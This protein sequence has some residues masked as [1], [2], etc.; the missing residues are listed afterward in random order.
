PQLQVDDV[1][2]A[3]RARRGFLELPLGI[4]ELGADLRDLRIF[5]ADLGAELLL[6]LAEARARL[7]LG[8]ARRVELA[9]LL[10]RVGL[11]PLQVEARAGAGL[12]QLA[13]LGDALAREVQARADL[14]RAV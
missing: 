5:A 12:H 9:L 7:R 13:I 11:D 1:A 14:L 8:V 6:D 10:E 2:V 3:R 4:V